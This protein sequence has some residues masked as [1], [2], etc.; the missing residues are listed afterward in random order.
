MLNLEMLWQLSGRMVTCASAPLYRNID[1]IGYRPEADAYL[2]IVQRGLVLGCSAS[3]K[4][5][6]L[7]SFGIDTLL[8]AFRKCTQFMLRLIISV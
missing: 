4:F 8:G 5:A 1:V 7:F 3:F 6:R 2:R